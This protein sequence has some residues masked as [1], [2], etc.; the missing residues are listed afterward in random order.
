MQRMKRRD[1]LACRLGPC[2]QFTDHRQP[3]LAMSATIGWISR[4][5][6][7]CRINAS[8]H[9]KRVYMVQRLP[10]PDQL[11]ATLAECACDG[12]VLHTMKLADQARQGFQNL[13]AFAT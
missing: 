2:L 1:K 9:Q 11:Q 7:A 6:Q 10:R 8:L 4:H 13:G 3:Y 5:M 12:L